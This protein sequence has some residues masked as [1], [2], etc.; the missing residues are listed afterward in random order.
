MWKKLALTVVSVLALTLPRVAHAGCGGDGGDGGTD[1][2]PKV[3]ATAQPRNYG[4]ELGVSATWMY[5]F[6]V[7]PEAI[8]SVITARN[9][10]VEE[11]ERK[12]R[13][14]MWAVAT[15]MFIQWTPPS[16]DDAVSGE[17]FVVDDLQPIVVLCEAGTATP[18]GGSVQV[19]DARSPRT[20]RKE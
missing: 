18:G 1:S 3:S 17:E 13:E 16:H 10:K 4:I 5:L 2:T 14:A 12:L 15:A 8:G 20:A 11:E 9:I 19:A 6:G 7:P